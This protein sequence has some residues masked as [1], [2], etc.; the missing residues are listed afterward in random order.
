[1]YP[2][3]GCP[4]SRSPSRRRV[5]RAPAIPAHACEHPGGVC[6]ANWQVVAPFGIRRKQ[7]R[8]LLLPR[9]V[10][11]RARSQAVNHAAVQTSRP[12]DQNTASHDSL[13][14]LIVPFCPRPDLDRPRDGSRYFHRFFW[15][16]EAITFIVPTHILE[17]GDLA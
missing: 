15:L 11:S 7:F 9:I 10:R 8:A 3:S 1:V 5:G 4:E 16:S 12:V 17:P 2:P 14:S 13:G 6:P